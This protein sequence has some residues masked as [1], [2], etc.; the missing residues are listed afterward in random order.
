MQIETEGTPGGALSS[1]LRLELATDG[2]VLSATR[3]ASCRDLD[4]SHRTIAGAMRI[5]RSTLVHAK[6]CVR[7]W[8]DGARLRQSLIPEPASDGPLDDH[9]LLASTADGIWPAPARMET[10][11]AAPSNAWFPASVIRHFS[12]MGAS[13]AQEIE[14]RE[15]LD[16]LRTG[17]ELSPKKIRSLTGARRVL[18]VILRDSESAFGDSQESRTELASRSAIAEFVGHR[19]EVWGTLDKQRASLVAAAPAENA[20]ASRW[21]ELVALAHSPSRAAMKALD[22]VPDVALPPLLAAASRHKLGYL[23]QRVQDIVMRRL[24]QRDL[25]AGFWPPIGKLVLDAPEIRP[26]IEKI[27]LPRSPIAGAQ[28]TGPATLPVLMAQIQRAPID[29]LRGSAFADGLS[30]VPSR[31]RVLLLS[32]LVNRLSRDLPAR[33]QGFVA[34][35]IERLAGLAGACTRMSGRFAELL[36]SLPPRLEQP[37][38]DARKLILSCISELEEIPISTVAVRSRPSITA[39]PQDHLGDLRVAL[40]ALAFDPGRA[41]ADELELRQSVQARLAWMTSAESEALTQLCREI[42]LLPPEA[43]G[44]LWEVG[45]A[46]EDAVILSSVGDLLCSTPWAE[47]VW[48]A[49]LLSSADGTAGALPLDD[50]TS[51]ATESLLQSRLVELQARFEVPAF[52]ADVQ[53]AFSRA[54]AAF[55]EAL[56]EVRKA[57]DA[58]AQVVES[59][60]EVQ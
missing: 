59:Y 46:R 40:H 2:E 6:G 39:H 5:A 53:R 21:A 43:V 48:V 17:V 41:L 20:A 4:L 30:T 55:D 54:E 51:T 13:L 60:R 37:F 35:A 12:A 15:Q 52:A 42:A 50:R 36:G 34:E 24:G 44:A 33:E 1:W 10:R 19:Y 32:R 7:D 22:D 29:A 23:T 31:E 38:L 57:I 56:A 3:G 47:S 49:V 26:W 11:S 25:A 27:V 9:P 8:L 14:A 58:L 45:V 28:D 16:S 18:E